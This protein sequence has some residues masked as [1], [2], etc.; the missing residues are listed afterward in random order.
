MSR[1]YTNY[2]LDFASSF[3]ARSVNVN[4]TV[5]YYCTK[6]VVMA[7]C[8]L[9]FPKCVTITIVIQRQKG[10]VALGTQARGHSRMTSRTER[11]VA[12]VTDWKRKCW[13][14]QDF[15][16]Y[17]HSPWNNN[18]THTYILVAHNTVYNFLCLSSITCSPKCKPYILVLVC[19]NKRNVWWWVM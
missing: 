18:K 15:F 9:Y 11:D 3:E 8:Y 5:H 10:S 1:H 13:A 16:S 2:L 12:R 4:I 14:A 17:V 19:A 7:T 6:T